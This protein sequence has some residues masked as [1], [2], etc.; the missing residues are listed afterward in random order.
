MSRAVKQ[1]TTTNR[2]PAAAVTRRSA[3]TEARLIAA[4]SRLFVDR[5][6]RA[7]TLAEIAHEA[8][9][10][11]RTVYVRFGTKAT[12]FVRVMDV[13]VGGDTDPTVL[14][15]RDWVRATM[16]GPT[17]DDRITAQAD[18]L[19]Q[20]FARLGPLMPAL[21]EAE[22]DDPDIAARSQ[23]AREE[24]ARHNAAFWAQLAADQLT[25]SALDLDW[26]IATSTL[27]GA[28]DTYLLMT[29][30]LR[31]TPAE[32]RTWRH[33]TWTSLAHSA[34]DSHHL[35]NENTRRTVRRR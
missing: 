1:V 20:L 22:V 11:A 30:T 7:T 5:G 21:R 28:A 29:Q 33:R 8:G 17:L 16:T 12:L 24:T 35:D 18:G 14:A 6:W 10:G 3:L 25:S 2:P 13:A 34:P 32:Y 15:D 4:A 9:V 27:L 23:A 19:A 31:W 26:V